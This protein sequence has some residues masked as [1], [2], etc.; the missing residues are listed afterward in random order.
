MIIVDGTQRLTQLLLLFDLAQSHIGPA[1]KKAASSKS[2]TTK[3]DDAPEFHAAFS[4][5]L[6]QL[7]IRGYVIPA[8][9]NWT[10]TAL[11]KIAE[12]SN[13]HRNQAV[14]KDEPVRMVRESIIMHSRTWLMNEILVFLLFLFLFFFC[15]FCFFCFLVFFLQLKNM[16]TAV[17]DYHTE[18]AKP[19]L[20][21][22]AQ[23]GPINDVLSQLTKSQSIPEKA[24][25]LKVR[26]VLLFIF[27]L[28]SFDLNSLPQ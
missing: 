13:A 18:N 8:S 28:V 6:L 11:S 17:I 15:F 27:N 22:M 12:L 14:V 3:S 1:K 5:E 7:T 16:S 10:K 4:S 21:G 25:L 2:K 20:E 9:L 19:S 26:F 23:F 24:L